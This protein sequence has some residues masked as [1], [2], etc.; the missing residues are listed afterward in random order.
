VREVDVNLK[1][2]RLVAQIL[3]QQG[4]QVDVIPSTVPVQYKA[5]AFVAIHADAN[6]SS[7]PNGFKA[8]RAS[9]SAQP[10]VDDALVEAL[11]AEYLPVSG[12][13]RSSA[14]TSAMLYYYAFAGGNASHTVA[15]TTPAAI[16]E[17]G[18]LTNTS[19]RAFINNKPDVVAGA[20]AAGIVRFLD[21][22]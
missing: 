20:I 14:I 7:A 9:R 5:D 10:A 6:N 21:R 11:Y 19:D 16:V 1:V 8:A 22:R 17:M 3:Q 2:A 12:M 15:P 4:A 18:Y 13:P